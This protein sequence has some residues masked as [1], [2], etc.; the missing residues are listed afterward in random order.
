MFPYVCMDLFDN[1]LCKWHIINGI[2][3]FICLLLISLLLSSFICALMLLVERQEV[4][5]ARKKLSGGMPAWLY[6]WARCSFSYGPA[7]A[8]ATHCLLLQLIQ[9][10]FT[11]LVLAQRQRA[12]N[13]CSSSR[14]HIHHFTTV[15]LSYI[16][17]TLKTHYP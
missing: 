7:D 11:F 16:H 17:H 1:P 15:I 13:G 3:V 8:T 9:T 10:G 5:L 4:H 2:Y 6:A 14:Y 12:V